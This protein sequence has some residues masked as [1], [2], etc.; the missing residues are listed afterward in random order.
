MLYQAIA[1]YRGNFAKYYGEIRG[2]EIEFAAEWDRDGGRTLDWPEQTRDG[3]RRILGFFIGE[4][5]VGPF[6]PPGLPA[7]VATGPP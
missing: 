3:I 6:P 4:A 2:R 7:A 5:P 1:W